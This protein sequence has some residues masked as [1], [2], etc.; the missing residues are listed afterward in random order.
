MKKLEEIAY[1]LSKI[2]G[3]IRYEYSELYYSNLNNP[4]TGQLTRNI[5]EFFIDARSLLIAM[6]KS[7]D[8]SFTIFFDSKDHHLKSLFILRSHGYDF[9]DDEA[10]GSNLESTNGVYELSFTVSDISAFDFI[11]GKSQKSISLKNLSIILNT[12]IAFSYYYGDHFA[13]S[14]KQY[15]G[16][17][18]NGIIDYHP[19]FEFSEITSVK[20]ILNYSNQLYDFV[21]N[22]PTIQSYKQLNPSIKFD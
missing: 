13:T 19:E 22:V 9:E 7:E 8:K 11:Y 15:F 3:N 14:T 1:Q 21:D 12:R 17:V 20:D 6:R 16:V 5:D 18:D 4:Q 2:T 10:D